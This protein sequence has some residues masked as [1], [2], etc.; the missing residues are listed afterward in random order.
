MA[1]IITRLRSR[2]GQSRKSRP[3]LPYS[4]VTGK[5]TSNLNLLIKPTKKEERQAECSSRKGGSRPL[6]HVFYRSLPSFLPS[7][8]TAN[9]SVTTV[10]VALTRCGTKGAIVRLERNSSPGSWLMFYQN[11]TP[12]ENHGNDEFKDL[13]YP[14]IPHCYFTAPHPDPRK[15]LTVWVEISPVLHT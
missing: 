10:E 13:F 1:V 12:G 4:D 15:S 11:W 3:F 14:L 9:P 2:W 7:F 6:C 8:H 5:E